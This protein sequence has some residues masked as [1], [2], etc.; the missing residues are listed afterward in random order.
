MSFYRYPKVVVRD[1]TDWEQKPHFSHYG[2]RLKDVYEN[3]KA[4]TGRDHYFKQSDQRYPWEFWSEVIASRLAAMFGISCATYDPAISRNYSDNQDLW[5]C[6]SR[7]LHKPNEEFKHGQEFLLHETP[8]FDVDKGK[9]HN[10]HGILKVLEDEKLAES[11]VLQFHK[12]LVFD[13]FIGN[14]DR[15]QENW[16][17]I[18]SGGKMLAGPSSYQGE[19]QVVKRSVRFV[20]GKTLQFY[21]EEFKRLSPMYDNGTSLGHNLV[22]KGVRERLQN[23]ASMQAYVSGSKAQSHVRWHGEKLRHFDLLQQIASENPVIVRNAINSI[24]DNYDSKRITYLLKQIDKDYDHTNS[25]FVLTP[26]R[27]EFIER[28][29]ALRALQLSELKETLHSL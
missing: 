10:Y 16:A 7:L 25:K 26:E 11:D 21:F 29:L 14:R 23:T 15:H 9:D 5:G 19:G 1:I 20:G 2:K 8:S 27:K 24:I 17:I 4:T 22:E 13:A 28:L 6:L 12:M 3:P 18:S